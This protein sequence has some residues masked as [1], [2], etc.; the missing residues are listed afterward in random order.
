MDGAPI[1]LLSLHETLAPGLLP[2][3]TNR[4][5]TGNMSTT[6]Q[7]PGHAS[8]IELPPEVSVKVITAAILGLALLCRSTLAVADGP[9]PFNQLAGNP[10]VHPVAVP[11]PQTS[12]NPAAAPAHPAQTVP[13]THGQK[14]MIGTGI[15]LAGLGVALMAFG[16]SVNQ[17]AIAGS[18]TR[19]VALGAGGGFAGIGVVLIV[20][21]AHHHKAH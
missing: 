8:R 21:G 14:V 16:A 12:D 20:V 19:D 9:I 5:A 1:F 18:E 17:K 7:F 11:L 6:F 13:L 15:A 3:V 2:E 10:G 4:L